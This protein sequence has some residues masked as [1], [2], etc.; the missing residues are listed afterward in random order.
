MKFPADILYVVLVLAGV[1]GFRRRG[2]PAMVFAAVVGAGALALDVAKLPSV[3]VQLG[4]LEMALAVV[5][6]TIVIYVQGLPPRIARHVGIGR[7]SREWEFDRRLHTYQDKLDTALLGY[8][9]TR[10]WPHYR[11]W[12]A[13]V[14]RDGRMLMGK[15]K[16]LTAP[17][18]A[19]AGVR[20]DYIDL[21]SG[22]LALIA[23][24]E[25]PDDDYT[26]QRGL[27]LRQRADI[28]RLKYRASADALTGRR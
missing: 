25:L 28:L 11:R 3:G 4:V 7:R 20:D 22:I 2:E 19:W 15:M 24:D 9:S 23:H 12:Q 16:G 26:A 18:D 6:V 21:Y 27:E 8:P 13:N 1:A 17:N 14:L 10:D 5:A